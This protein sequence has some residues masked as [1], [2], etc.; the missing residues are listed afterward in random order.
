MPGTETSIE[1]AI[2]ATTEPLSV[3][4]DPGSDSGYV[5]VASAPDF[6]PIPEPEHS[7]ESDY[8]PEPELDDG[9]DS[10]QADNFEG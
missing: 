6:D 3:S 7:P 10:D 9:H 1:A 2:E 4:D 5:D 8:A